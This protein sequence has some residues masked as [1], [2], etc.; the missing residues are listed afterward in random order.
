MGMSIREALDQFELDNRARRLS[1]RT[2]EYHRFALT[3]FVA[4]CES[5]DAR[6]VGGITPALI[7]AYLV[8]LQDRQLADNTIH[9]SAR[10]IKRFLNFCVQEELIALSPMRKVRMPTIAKRILPAFTEAEVER[11]LA[12]SW[13]KR[14]EAV[15]LVLLDTGL[16]ASEFVALDGS[17]VDLARGT[18]H[19]RQGKGGKDRTVYLGQQSREALGRYLEHRTIRPSGALWRNRRGEGRLTT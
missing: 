10:A 11:L 5:H 12:A 6:T 2:L 16:R 15:I 7:R 14:D 3:P 8:S 9:G 18:V 1:P 4:W 19:V 13:S 17:D